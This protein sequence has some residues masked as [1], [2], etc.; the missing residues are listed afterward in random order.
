MPNVSAVHTETFI[1]SIG[2]N[3]HLNASNYNN[4]WTGIV[5]PRL[6]ELGM[7]FGRD[8]VVN[9][10]NNLA[11]HAAEVFPT[12]RWHCLTNANHSV[13]IDLA[14]VR[15]MGVNVTYGVE[16][17]NEPDL[18]NQNVSLV[19]SHQAALY[20]LIKNT[21]DTAHLTVIGP[22]PTGLN[23]SY[24]N[25]LSNIEAWC[26]VGNIHSYR[27]G[28][29]PE[30][31][32]T[33]SIVNGH[34]NGGLDWDYFNI[35][36]VVTPTKPIWCTECGYHNAMSTS[37]GHR[38]TPYNV[39]GK[40]MPRMFLWHY[41]GRN[42]QK[43]FDYEFLDRQTADVA[44]S[45]DNFGII[46]TNG[47]RKPAFFAVKN[48][49]ALLSD[50]GSSFTP[51][52]LNITFSSSSLLK[53]ALMQ[54]RDGI[55]YCAMWLAA[56]EYNPDT[57]TE[58]V[59]ATQ[60]ITVTAP[61]VV[62]AAHA[63]C[64]AVD[65]T[66]PPYTSV[67]VAGGVFTIPVNGVVKIVRMQTTG[68]P[69]PASID[70]TAAIS[71]PTC[72]VFAE[73][74]TNAFDAEASISMAMFTMAATAT[75]STLTL[76]ARSL[77]ESLIQ[78]NASFD[79]LPEE[80]RSVAFEIC[81]VMDILDVTNADNLGKTE[82]IDYTIRT[83]ADT[84]TTASFH[85]LRNFA[86][87]DSALLELRVNAATATTTFQA[88]I[89]I[90]GQPVGGM[91][92]VPVYN[93]SGALSR[94]ATS[95]N[96]AFAGSKI[97][98]ELGGIIGTPANF[99]LSL[100]TVR[101]VDQV[102]GETWN[103]DMSSLIRGVAEGAVS[104]TTAGSVF[105]AN[106]TI[107]RTSPAAWQILSQADSGLFYIMSSGPTAATVGTTRTFP[108]ATSLSPAH[109]FVMQVAKDGNVKQRRVHVPVGRNGPPTRLYPLDG[110]TIYDN[111]KGRTFYFMARG[112]AA[113]DTS[114]SIVGDARFTLSNGIAAQ[115]LLN[116]VNTLSASDYVI[117]IVAS[118]SLGT[119]TFS[120]T[121][122][123]LPRSTESTFPWQ[124]HVNSGPNLPVRTASLP[125]TLRIVNDSAGSVSANNYVHFK[126]SFNRGD[127]S[128]NETPLFLWPTTISGNPT[129]TVTIQA[130]MDEISYWRD[131]T[132]A[133]TS[134]RM[135]T[136]ILKTADGMAASEIVSLGVT[137]AVG[138]L[139]TTPARSLS[140]AK[141]IVVSQS[142][143]VHAL[144]DSVSYT[145]QLTLS[146]LNDTRAVNYARGKNGDGMFC[147]TKFVRD[148][149]GV[150]QHAD[151]SVHWY[152]HVYD[153]TLTEGYVLTE[154]MPVLHNTWMTSHASVSI[155]SL[156]VTCSTVDVATSF[157]AV[158]DHYAYALAYGAD[159]GVRPFQN[160][161]TVNTL[162][163]DFSKMTAYLGETGTFHKYMPDIGAVI[164]AP[165]PSAP[166]YI[167]CGTAK[168]ASDP[169]LSDGPL[170]GG[171]NY[172]NG[173]GPQADWS[174]KALLTG[175]GPWLNVCR[176]LAGEWGA[177]R[178][179][180]IDE[181]TWKIR[182][183]NDGYAGGQ[184]SLSRYP[185]ITTEPQWFRTSF[186]PS[187]AAPSVGMWD[188]QHAADPYFTLAFISG[189]RWWLDAKALLANYFAVWQPTGLDATAYGFRIQR[190]A[191]T[192]IYFAGGFHFGGSS[193][194]REAAWCMKHY[195]D[196]EWLMG[197][198]D[199][200]YPVF[201]DY[202]SDPYRLYQKYLIDDIPFTTSSG[203][204]H[205]HNRFRPQG[206][207]FWRV[208]GYQPWEGDY[209][210]STL[211]ID[212]MRR[213]PWI[214][215]AVNDVA[216]YILPTLTY[217]RG[218]PES[219]GGPGCR[220]RAT[221][222][223]ITAEAQE[224]RVAA[225]GWN[226]VAMSWSTADVK[227]QT[228]APMPVPEVN[229]IPEWY[230][231]DAVACPLG[232]IRDTDGAFLDATRPVFARGAAIMGVNAGIPNAQ[233]MLDTIQAMGGYTDS[234]SHYS[235]NY[236]RWAVIT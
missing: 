202:Q 7:Q 187:G 188:N 200:R 101:G 218:A 179:H 127:I 86:A 51:G 19:R 103:V 214:G 117:N 98:L 162:F 3:S 215:D 92:G 204:L 119:T 6:L 34:R 236:V 97:Q 73:A 8:S 176:V 49:I 226:G 231:A 123:V 175:S 113:T 125:Q 58:N 203:S 205:W 212:V 146:A 66:P 144:L 169:N 57:K 45:E 9:G 90:D 38:P 104:S 172:G 76:Q 20:N 159:P 30:H 100:K 230:G 62:A 220:F 156:R 63:T 39:D 148:S 13:S 96:G 40:Y 223:F 15:N 110:I 178:V 174:I 126:M 43:S 78:D 52:V 60:N 193:A 32:G 233:D 153:G 74:S 183:A 27:G 142:W 64:L 68:T 107:N 36:R 207:Q 180:W 105:L 46:Q 184:Q 29:N 189:R 135:A 165:S 31:P 168:F 201:K 61:A 157:P 25:S 50:P 59:A 95:T 166:I 37:S 111:Q 141:A 71:L 115:A 118:N 112:T 124:T 26:D 54:K 10:N 154:V 41:F 198:S 217:G 121:V 197:E 234:P 84:S 150:T 129:T 5:K 164:A 147:V 4:S 199:L 149:D 47:T 83:P 163:A 173:L 190:I 116:V 21:S 229:G 167:P 192:N 24:A 23:I 151:M 232:T 209:L 93:G 128:L 196:T 120:R 210:A 2:F 72:L 109:S 134:L 56:D 228:M 139:S 195:S 11:Q 191:D 130:Q 219:K 42:I 91:T 137:K 69:A 108:G 235:V 216:C 132:S 80:V 143:A 224:D 182:A 77:I 87:Y 161:G 213:R 53:T 99:A 70:A 89:L 133:A 122:H 208:N 22:S 194:E 227:T 35:G 17:T 171:Q 48:M 181:T 44:D 170:A 33:G 225:T 79:I 75:K 158:Y 211:T 140:A 85:V 65:T 1:D 186:T 114:L 177:Y 206:W 16:G 185:G 145:A 138:T 28:R 67:T 102:L 55:Y 82:Q 136:F 160:R 131:S 106:G 14:F 81:N 18:N 12:I 94:V 222:N 152:A 155:R 221:A 88:S